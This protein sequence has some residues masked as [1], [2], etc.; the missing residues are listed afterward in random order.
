MAFC[1]AMAEVGGLIAT[2]VGKQISSKLEKLVKEEIALLWGFQDEVE[3]MD[4]KMKDLEAV[5][6]DADDRVRRGEKD[7][8]AVGRWLTKFKSVA[9]DVEDVLDEL[10]AN[11]L[12]KKTQS[13]VLTHNSLFLNTSDFSSRLNLKYMSSYNFE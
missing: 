7:G 4:E 9:Y 10:D 5:M 3:G 12:I 11:E 8:E 13:K 6:H 2:A 1:Q